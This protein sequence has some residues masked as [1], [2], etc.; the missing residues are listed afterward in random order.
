MLS[1]QDCVAESAIPVGTDMNLMLFGLV[2]GAALSLG[3]FAGPE[4]R[5]MSTNKPTAEQCATAAREGRNLLGC[6]APGAMVPAS[7]NTSPPRQP[8]PPANRSREPR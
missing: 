7:S 3:A 5:D 1:S 4:P 8:Q 2:S 6:A